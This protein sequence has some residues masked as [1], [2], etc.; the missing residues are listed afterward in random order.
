MYWNSFELCKETNIN[1]HIKIKF[2]AHI[3]PDKTI[4]LYAHI[5]AK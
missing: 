1:R 5:R 2:Q 3:I 4:N